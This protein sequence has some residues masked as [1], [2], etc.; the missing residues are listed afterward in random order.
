MSKASHNKKAIADILLGMVMELPQSW[1]VYISHIQIWLLLSE[2]HVKSLP[3]GE[4]T[5]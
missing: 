5:W 1:P 4:Y 2:Q 3:S